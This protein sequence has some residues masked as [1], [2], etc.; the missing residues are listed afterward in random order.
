MK[1]VEYKIKAGNELLSCSVDYFDELKK[2]DVIC[3][4]GGG[5]TDKNTIRYLSSLLQK[6]GFSV[7]RF[8]FSGQGESS[9]DIKQSSLAKRIDEAISVLSYFNMDKKITVIGTSMGGYVGSVLTS[10]YD[11]CNLILF[12]PAAYSAKAKPL[13]FDS[14]FTD[15]IRRKDSFLE[16]DI[17]DILKVYQNKALLIY[18]EED[19]I[20]PCK[21][22][23]IYK[24]SLKNAKVFEYFEVKGCPHSMHVWLDKNKT[25]Q[26]QIKESV[27]SL[28]KR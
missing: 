26:D 13:R 15:E 16:T 20:I 23:E 24:D 27:M 5:P 28:L 8:D 3:L 4:H 11:V 22:K 10:F 9:G 12:C 7:V 1:T 21:V 14:G 17:V 25:E 19:T 6:T 2:P 18:G